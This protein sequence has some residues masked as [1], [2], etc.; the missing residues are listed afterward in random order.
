MLVLGGGGGAQ[1]VSSSVESKVVDKAGKKRWIEAASQ[2][3]FSSGW[4]VNFE[5]E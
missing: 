3:A 1:I 2:M 4:G 5:D